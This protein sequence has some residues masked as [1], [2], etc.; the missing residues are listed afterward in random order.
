MNNPIDAFKMR[1]T[2]RANALA[3]ELRAGGPEYTAYSN[4]GD[5]SCWTVR[6]QNGAGKAD[7]VYVVDLA[8]DTC[9]C[10]CHIEKG[11]CKHGIALNLMLDAIAEE[12]AQEAQC[13]EYEKSFDGQFEK[14]A[15]A[16]GL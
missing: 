7:T 1:V 16:A 14:A 15:I 3:L 2:E 12:E 11:Y 4:N 6:K 8:A 13:A 5:S 10:P 9:E